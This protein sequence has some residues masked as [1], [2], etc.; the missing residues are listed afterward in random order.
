MQR[1][2]TGFLN[3]GHFDAI[4]RRYDRIF[5][6]GGPDELL[7]AL[8]PQPGDLVLD[9]AGGTGRV[10]GTFGPEL[11][12]VVCDPAPLM[13]HEAQGKGLPV[14]ACVAEHLPFADDS[15][16]RVIV[17][18]AF[19]HL[20]DQ[21]TAAS[22]LVRVLAPGGRLVVEEPDIRQAVVKVAALLERLLGVRSRF[23]SLPDMVR[24]F[25]AAGATIEYTEEG[26]GTNVRVVIVGR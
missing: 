22:E 15:F 23:F 1:G 24:I 3:M 13:L 8:Q 20:I 25:E 17:V 19:H 6:Y 11:Q 2:E 9:V 18:D 5:R 7:Q 12:V 21:R 14:C 4:A 16:R 10:S 26:L